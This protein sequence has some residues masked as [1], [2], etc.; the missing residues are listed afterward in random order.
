MRGLSALSL[1][2]LSLSALRVRVLFFGTVSAGL[3]TACAGS[4]FWH[5]VCRVSHLALCL[6][7]E[8]RG[9]SLGTVSVGS[10]SLGT[11]SVGLGS[12]SEGAFSKS[13]AGIAKKVNIR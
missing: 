12:V 10:L 7:G 3:G 11:V 6:R 13:R 4:L 1:L 2:G 8:M 5:C 9:L